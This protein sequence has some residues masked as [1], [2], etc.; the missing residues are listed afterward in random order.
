MAE[1]TIEQIVKIG[2]AVLV[3]VAVVAG[4]YLG[5]RNYIFPY[6]KDLGPG[7]AAGVVLLFFRRDR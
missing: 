7:N 3:L 4:V 6:F 2:I 1:L 5:F